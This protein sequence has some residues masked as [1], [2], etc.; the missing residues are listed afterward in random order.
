MKELIKNGKV[1]IVFNDIIIVDGIVV[2][3]L[4]DLIFEIIN[5][6]VDEIVVVEEIEIVEL[7]LFMMES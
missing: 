2:K 4:G 3:I 7:I 5:E 6:L 1:I